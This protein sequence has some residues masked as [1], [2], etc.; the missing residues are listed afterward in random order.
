[1]SRNRSDQRH[2]LMLA[3]LVPAGCLDTAGLLAEARGSE[4]STGKGGEAE[5]GASGS[6]GAVDT[7]APPSTSVVDATTSGSISLDETSAASET[8]ETGAQSTPCSDIPPDALYTCAE[9]AG[10]GKCNEPWMVGFCDA[11][12]G[13]CPEPGL[14]TADPSGTGAEGV[15]ECGV[16]PVNPN[17]TVQARNLLC[18]IYSISGNHVLSG[19]Q[20]TSWDNPEG[21]ID[22]YVDNLGVYPAILGGDFLYTDGTTERAIAYWEAGGIPM[23]RYHMGAPPLGD[24][25]ENSQGTTNLNNVLTPGTAEYESFID[26]LDYAADELLRLQAANAAVLFAPLHEVQPNGWFWWSKGS[27]Q[28]FIALWQL[29][30]DYLTETRGVNNLVWLMPFSGSPN[31]AYDPGPAYA[32]LAGPD[33]YGTNQPFTA[34]YA[35]TRNIV[36]TTRPIPLHETGTIPNPDQMFQNGAAPWVLFNIWSGYQ[37]SANDLADI[38]NT[39][40]SEYTITRDEVPNLD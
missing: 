1:M 26:K 24:S 6:T 22:F 33:T 4:S 11:S 25:Y 12:C 8:G 34:M 37:R 2:W 31:G 28:Q 27:G 10:W 23:I 15:S 14:D 5:D 36:G 39:Y 16:E 18:Y 32:D 30:F 35:T 19:Q 13:R 21:D 20:E 29:M 17:A 40:A 38:Q 9:Q 3:L 7:S